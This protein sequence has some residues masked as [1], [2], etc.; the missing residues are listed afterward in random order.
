[1]AIE[2]LSPGSGNFYAPRFEIEIQNSTLV[3]EMSKAIISV[4]VEERLDEGASFSLRLHDAF[5]LKTQEFKWLD[6]PLLNVGNTVSVKMGYESTLRPMLMGKIS[7]L[8][9]DFFVGETPAISVSGQDLS[10][11]FMKRESP[12]ETFMNMSYSDIV[13]SIAKKAGLTAQ[14]DQA[15]KFS[16]VIRKTNRESYF[17]FLERLAREVGFE[18]KI[19]RQTL[20]FIKPEDNKKEILTLE[21]GKDIISFSPELNTTQAFSEVEVRWNNPQDPSTPIV[22][23]ATAGSERS[24]EGGR[25]TASQVAQAQHGAPKRVVTNIPVCSVDHANSVALAIL[26]QAS[27]RFIGG[28]TECIGIPQIRPGVNV[29]LDRMG[30]R[31][32]GKYYVN[33]ATHTIDDNGYKTSFTVKRNAV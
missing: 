20:Y 14:T 25:Q 19:D 7:G 31:F 28:T 24:Q 16:P 17:S 4:S 30:K 29:K 15:A 18:F 5:D 10:Y 13:R 12:E 27:D 33:S 23:R 2:K 6:H 1:M 9:S 3:A 32:S 26:N 22:G 8:S 11:D 21:L